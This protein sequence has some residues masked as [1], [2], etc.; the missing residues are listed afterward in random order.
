MADDIVA[1]LRSYAYLDDAFYNPWV[2]GEAADEIERLRA[3]LDVYAC[4]C[5]EGLCCEEPCGYIAR[6]ALAGEKTDERY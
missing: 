6:V 5:P 1:R 2:Y 4:I 3:A